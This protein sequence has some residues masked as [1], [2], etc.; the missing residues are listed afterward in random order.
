MLGLDEASCGETFYPVE[1]HRPFLPP[2]DT[3]SSRSLD[4]K[5]EKGEGHAKGEVV[6]V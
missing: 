2:M 4:Q 6:E 5:G 1:E 3:H